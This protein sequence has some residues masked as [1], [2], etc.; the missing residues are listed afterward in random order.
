MDD[1]VADENKLLSHGRSKNWRERTWRVEFEA[2]VQEWYGRR[3]S[4]GHHLEFIQT[5]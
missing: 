1:G 3:Y 2:N 5:K 4:G